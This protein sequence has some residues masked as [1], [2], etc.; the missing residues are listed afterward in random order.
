[1]RQTSAPRRSILADISAPITG[2]ISRTNLTK[3][4]RGRSGER[5]ADDNRQMGP[6][7]VT[8]PVS[9]RE[10][11]KAQEDR[12]ERDPK[13]TKVRIPSDRCSRIISWESS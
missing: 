8:F 1:M 13:S 3:G 4:Q 9:Q 10:F 5:A 7:Y 2:K 12:G 11:L 6:M